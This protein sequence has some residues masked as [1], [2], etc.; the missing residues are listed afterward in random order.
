MSSSSSSLSSLGG[1]AA[2]AAAAGAAG[3][4]GG[5]GA[6]SAKKALRVSA[7]LKVMSVAAAIASRF[8]MPFT[9][10]WGTEATL[11]YLMASEMA[12]T[13]LTPAWNLASRSAS[14]MSRISGSNT[15]PLSYTLEMISP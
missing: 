13:F 3:A 11:G 2:A 10:L 6:G 4:A 7:S 12:A 5:E 8:F 1:G 15:L 9:M 14:V